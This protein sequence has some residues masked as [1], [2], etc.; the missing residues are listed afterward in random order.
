MGS[1]CG[2]QRSQA[3]DQTHYLQPLPRRK[4]IKQQQEKNSSKKQ[5][6]DELLDITKETSAETTTPQESVEKSTPQEAPVQSLP[7]TEVP[8]ELLF[9]QKLVALSNIKV[10]ALINQKKQKPIKKNHIKKYA[11]R[12]PPPLK[13]GEGHLENG[14]VPL[15]NEDI[16]A[17]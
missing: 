4:K 1:A 5:V 15:E 9:A 8:A 6:E 3:H 2:A 10:R 17:E 13:M 7:F 16:F 14:E 12:P 11:A